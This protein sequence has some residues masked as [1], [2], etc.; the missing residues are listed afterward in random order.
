MV[1]VRVIRS[2]SVYAV[3]VILIA[4]PL[5][6]MIRGVKV[7]ECFAEGAEEGLKTAFRVLPYMVTMLFVIGIVRETGAMDLFVALMAPLTS[8]VHIP[9]EILPMGIMRS[10]SGSGAQAMLG[11]ILNSYGPDSLVGFSASVA[12]GSTETT[13]Y[14]A[15]LYYG[16]VGV[17]NTRYTVPLG[18]AADAVSL[19]AAAVISRLMF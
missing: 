16:S 15:A 11:D 18:L 2:I 3:P 9:P 4:V 8:T 19:I 17:K 13:L 12:M 14:C 10:L 1:F 5:Y 6:G 7:Y